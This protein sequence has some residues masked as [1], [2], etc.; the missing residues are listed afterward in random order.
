MTLYSVFIVLRKE[1][2][3]PRC[4]A[5]D[6]RWNRHTVSLVSWV[7]T[8]VRLTISWTS[9]DHSPRV[10]AVSLYGSG[11]DMRTCLIRPRPIRRG[12]LHWRPL[13]FRLFVLSTAKQTGR[14]RPVYCQIS[15]DLDKILHTPTVVRNTL[16]GRLRP[17]SARGRLQ[18]KPKRLFFL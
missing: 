10:P 12:I 7:M 4:R 18:A 9:Y 6:R 3:F 11:V 16:V 14:Q 5:M 1:T 8:V 15:T 17:R 13:S 2:A